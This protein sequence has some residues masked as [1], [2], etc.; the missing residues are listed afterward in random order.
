MTDIFAISPEAVTALTRR[1]TR[2]SDRYDHEIH[3]PR[4]EQVVGGLFG[5]IEIAGLDHVDDGVGRLGQFVGFVL[6]GEEACER[7]VVD[8]A[9]ALAVIV[10]HI[11]L[12]TVLAGDGRVSPNVCAPMNS[13]RLPAAC[14]CVW[15]S[16][17]ARC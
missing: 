10:M 8:L 12:T 13:S 17:R 4:S 11:L 9:V 3:S 14:G 15:R 6:T 5:G 1:A 16:L 7:R 2:A